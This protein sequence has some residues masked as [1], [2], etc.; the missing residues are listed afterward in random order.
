MASF[1]SIYFQ[2]FHRKTAILGK[3]LLTNYQ[4]SDDNFDQELNYSLS[5]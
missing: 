1:V 5:N 3:L 4:I 2:F